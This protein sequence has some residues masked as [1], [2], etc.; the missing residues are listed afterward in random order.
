MFGQS[1]KKAFITEND[2]EKH[3]IKASKMITIDFEG[4]SSLN[5]TESPK[6][7]QKD[8]IPP[9]HSH[10]PVKTLVSETKEKEIDDDDFYDDRRPSDEES[11]LEEL[12]RKINELRRREEIERKQMEKDKLN[13]A[14][15]LEK[16]LAEID[17]ERKRKD[18]EGSITRKFCLMKV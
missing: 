8:D 15:E 1:N 13:A 2:N 14:E 3:D 16:R 5:K 6:R 10:P 18:E 4:D 11:R 7:I 9:H 12:D 17:A